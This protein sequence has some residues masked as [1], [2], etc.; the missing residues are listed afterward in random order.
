[1]LSKGISQN[2]FRKKLELATS[3]VKKI[4]IAPNQ[5]TKDDYADILNNKKRIS[6]N[7]HIGKSCQK[8]IYF[9]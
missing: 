6:V 7:Q 3:L 9:A 4:P 5:L 8:Y 2:I 1:M